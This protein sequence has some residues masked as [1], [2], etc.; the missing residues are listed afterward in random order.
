M[1]LDWRFLKNEP[2]WT[3]HS[4]YLVLLGKS[5][6]SEAVAVQVNSP[7]L[8][9]PLAD[10]FT[11]TVGRVLSTVTESEEVTLAPDESVMASVGVL[12]LAVSVAPAAQYCSIGIFLPIDWGYCTIILVCARS[13][14]CKRVAHR[15][16]WSGDGG[17]YGETRVH[18][19]DGD[20]IIERSTSAV[21][22]GDIPFQKQWCIP[23]A[24]T[25]VTVRRYLCFRTGIKDSNFLV[26]ITGSQKNSN[27]GILSFILTA[28]WYRQ[29]S[30]FEIGDHSLRKKP[31]FTLALWV[32]INIR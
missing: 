20:W 11:V 25:T 12:L 19:G 2:S 27:D 4:W 16:S 29:C 32:H 26:W 21:C 17:G 23:R 24:F 15:C 13:K 10:L 8:V 14:A 9:L 3:I 1:W 28:S 18:I 30:Q 7:V 5:S 22:I 6:T 31:S